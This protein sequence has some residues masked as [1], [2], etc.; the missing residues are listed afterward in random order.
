MK[1]VDKE[2]HNKSN[3]KHKKTVSIDTSSHNKLNKYI[4]KKYSDKK[5]KNNQNIT[6]I[7]NIN[8]VNM[9]MNQEKPYKNNN[10]SIDGQISSQSFK[11]YN[12]SQ[13]KKK[14]NKR[15]NTS[16]FVEFDQKE[17]YLNSSKENISKN[18]ANE[19]KLYSPY[20]NSKIRQT[21]K[22]RKKNGLNT[23]RQRNR[24]CKQLGNLKLN[25]NNKYSKKK[26]KQKNKSFTDNVNDLILN[27]KSDFSEIQRLIRKKINIEDSEDAIYEKN[28]LN[29]PINIKKKNNKKSGKI[30]DVEDFLNDFNLNTE[31]KEC[32]NDSEH[33][34]KNKQEN[35]YY[36][37]DLEFLKINIPYTIKV[38][39]TKK[40]KEMKNTE[41]KYIN[42]NSDYIFNL[43]RELN[44]K[45][46]NNFLLLKD[47][48]IKLEIKKSNIRYT[49]DN[50]RKF[51][52]D[53]DEE[54]INFV[55][56]KFIEKNIRYLSELQSKNYISYIFGN[57]NNLND[58]IK[59][60][61]NNYSGYILT[62][63]EKGKKSLEVEL[64][65]CNLESINKILKNEKFEINGE[66][67]LFAP[68]GILNH[69]K[70]ENKNIKWE[71][72]KIKEENK[73]ANISLVKLKEVNIML[74]MKLGKIKHEYDILVED[75]KSANLKK[76]ELQE[77][78][79][80]KNTLIKSLEQK[81]KENQ[82]EIKYLEKTISLIDYD[83]NIDFSIKKE[84]K[85]QIINKNVK[86]QKKDNID[87][88]N[89]EKP[90]ISKPKLLKIEKVCNI[91]FERLKIAKD[92]KNLE[93][94]INN[95]LP[96]K[97]KNSFGKNIK[98]VGTEKFTYNSLN[99]NSKM[100][101]WIYDK[102]I[103]IGKGLNI[104]LQFIPN[105]NKKEK[106]KLFT[107]L[108]IKKEKDLHFNQEIYLNNKEKTQKKNIKENEIVKKDKNKIKEIV[109]LNN[110]FFE[111][112][113]KDNKKINNAIIIEKVNDINFENIKKLKNNN[114]KGNSVKIVSILNLN[115]EGIKNKKNNCLKI[116]KNQIL[117]FVKI[118]E[119][120][121][122]FKNITILNVL[123]LFY[124]KTKKNKNIELNIIK[125]ENF[126][127]EGIKK[128]NKETIKLDKN[129]LFEIIKN[130]NF[131]FVNN[132][133]NIIKSFKNN[134]IE[135]LNNIIYEK[136]IINVSQNINNKYE[137]KN[138]ANFSLLSDKKNNKNITKDKKF[139]NL[140]IYKDIQNN[141]FY[142]KVNKDK[143][144]VDNSLYED[145][146]ET[147]K[148]GISNKSINLGNLSNISS[149]GRTEEKIEKKVTFTENKRVEKVNKALDKIR[150]RTQSQRYK[151]T[152]NNNLLNLNY[153]LH[154]DILKS[155]QNNEQ[156]EQ[157]E[158]KGKFKYR[159]S[160]RIMQ[161][162]KQLEKEIIKEDENGNESKNEANDSDND[163]NKHYRH[164]IAV[165]LISLIPI[166]NKKK[167]KKKSTIFKEGI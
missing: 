166:D 99:N 113:K 21:S 37:K 68:A 110:I 25:F 71:N 150:K 66:H 157:K 61:K 94:Y 48:I 165:D 163:N 69:L 136:I 93:K 128:I 3:K 101:N 147:P 40:K 96:R 17:N 148:R 141:I 109:N 108:I 28:H 102:N 118:R 20:N 156:N 76:K 133:K 95:N 23:T 124:E 1:K 53:N 98:I 131:S 151:K 152:T 31:N 122:N 149:F 16:L 81:I 43:N 5:E 112:I 42:T 51:I 137:I 52:F 142:Q 134:S 164:S 154:P 160:L 49:N 77:E 91:N 162:A 126:S 45:E 90:L 80:K 46:F 72:S 119:Q 29:T 9:I 117:N 85:L 60:K 47:N 22:N 143:K 139:G 70:E 79:N 115:Y 65:L 7:N 87:K 55:K 24:S 32:Y 116:E 121:N 89:N 58:T 44:K 8:I 26:N 145:I 59:K 54:I 35:E 129:K 84:I 158:P 50:K 125:V 12:N 14:K 41:A 111:A 97:I 73:N 27:K 106:K 33:N 130:A 19:S 74:K 36:D 105:K 15:S 155:L 62:K 135:K 127:F 57:S 107:S 140:S 132:S 103:L 38:N 30:Y 83:K 2:I 104:N 75:L 82:N 144:I 10:I 56:N 63:N 88:N 6:N 92:N 153:E 138:E 120:N 34:F 86:N 123:N 18:K 159:Q 100:K 67:L 39:L 4:N 13:N 64:N 11:K 146:N 114:N 161:I 167:K 78:N